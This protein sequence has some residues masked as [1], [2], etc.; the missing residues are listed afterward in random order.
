MS[1]PLV[2][3][4][5]KL[6][7][8]AKLKQKK[9]RINENKIILEGRRLMEQLAEYKV[10]PQEIFYTVWQDCLG[11]F[12]CPKYQVQERD[13]LRFTDTDSPPQIAGLYHLP[14][15][16]KEPFK[17]ALY[18]DGASDPG[19]MG[20]IFRLAAA[21][22]IRQI[23]LSPDCCEICNPKVIRASLGAV[24]KVPFDMVNYDSLVALPARLISLDLNAAIPLKEFRPP[25]EPA[26]Y[27]LGSEAHGI[28]KQLLSSSDLRLK[29]EMTE[30]MESLNVAVACGILCYHLYVNK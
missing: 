28:S 10:F 23:L 27:I 13:M 8:L 1:K 5:A 15:P 26:I 18:L 19:N 24:Y 16:R 21:F 6:S 2:I 14:A 12:S 22:D 30:G 25:E 3:S 17:R 9:H 20:T 4:K 7:D 29:I 11:K